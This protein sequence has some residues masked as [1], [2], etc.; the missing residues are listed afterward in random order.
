MKQCLRSILKCAL[1]KKAVRS[2]NTH[3]Y[4]VME[5]NGSLSVDRL[6]ATDRF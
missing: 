2:L 3:S 6:R 4:W 1:R 5:R